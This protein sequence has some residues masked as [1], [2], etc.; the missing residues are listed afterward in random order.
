MEQGTVRICLYSELTRVVLSFSLFLPSGGDAVKPEGLICIS[1]GREP[2]LPPLLECLRDTI[3]STFSWK[4]L[5]SGVGKTH[6][7]TR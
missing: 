4:I 2:A 5:P 6:T 3:E 1:P 7:H